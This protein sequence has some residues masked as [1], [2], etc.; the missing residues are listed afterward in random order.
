MLKVQSSL[1]DI[2]PSQLMNSKLQKIIVRPVLWMTGPI[3]TI[4]I[5]L[6]HLCFRINSPRAYAECH[7][8]TNNSDSR[9]TYAKNRIPYERRGFIDQTRFKLHPRLGRFAA[10]SLPIMHVFCIHG[11]FQF[12]FSGNKRLAAWCDPSVRFRQTSPG[13]LFWDFILKGAHKML[14]CVYIYKCCALS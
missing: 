9:G 10:S 8:S 4:I 13:L 12:S 5:H 14:M 7:Q 2:L 3:Q 1:Y 11:L 6:Q